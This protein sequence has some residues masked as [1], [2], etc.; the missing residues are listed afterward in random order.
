MCEFFGCDYCVL[1]TLNMLCDVEF[2]FIQL[3]NLLE[4][5][6]VY[7]YVCLV[8]LV[9]KSYNLLISCMY[10]VMFVRLLELLKIRCLFIL[11]I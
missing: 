5:Y 9:I 2:M 6:Y 10:K 11:P 3:L 7:V 1:L 4:R 8:C